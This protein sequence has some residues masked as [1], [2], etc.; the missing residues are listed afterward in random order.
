MDHS[1]SPL[2]NKKNETYTEGF[3]RM[4]VIVT[5]SVSKVKDHRWLDSAFRLKCE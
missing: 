4:I 5:L 1:I 3:K 2:K